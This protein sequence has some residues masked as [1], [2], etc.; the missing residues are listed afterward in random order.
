MK[1]NYI[2]ILLL[3]VIALN[4]SAQKPSKNTKENI[5]GIW[6]Y[7]GIVIQG[8]HANSGRYNPAPPLSVKVISSD[9]TYS[10]FSF[11]PNGP[12][13]TGTGT[14]KILNDTVY[15][16]HVLTNDNSSLVGK[17]NEMVVRFSPDG[18]AMSNSLF[19][20]QL[21]TGRKVD[22]M[23]IEYWE[24]VEMSNQFKG[25]SKLNTKE[26]VDGVVESKPSPTKQTKPTPTQKK[27]DKKRQT[28][29]TTIS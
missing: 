28:E 23:T 8:N 14:Y 4:A 15:A 18:N 24:R 21:A 5:V 9:G 26:K 7:R 20:E 2:I 12:V 19:L 25:A 27:Q 3:F 1:K 16:E 22:V 13:I 10:A 6:S 17:T 29:F 11:T